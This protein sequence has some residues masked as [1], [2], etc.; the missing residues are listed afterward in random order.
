MSDNKKIIYF[1]DEQNSITINSNDTEKSTNDDNN[2]NTYDYPNEPD[3][4]STPDDT[5]D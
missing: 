2:D 4:I 3:P 5:N 1:D